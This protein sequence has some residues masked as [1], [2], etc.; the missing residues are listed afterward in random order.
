MA[1]KNNVIEKILLP[2]VKNIIVVASGKGGVGK[3]TVSAGLA[4][5]LA[6]DGRK[7]GLMDADIYG[8]SIPLLTGTEGFKPLMLQVGDTPRMTPAEKWGIKIQSIA[9]FIEEKAAMW[10]GPM[11][12][13]TLMQLVEQTAWG[14]LDYLVIDL[15][16]GTGDIQLSLFQRLNITGALVVTSPQSISVSDAAKAVELIVHEQFKIPIMGVVENMSWFTPVAHP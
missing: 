2:T 12:S 8:A 3:S 15:P 10:R 11:A 6:R 5:A 9:Y 1:T 4:L 7:V 14:E 16:P 13:N